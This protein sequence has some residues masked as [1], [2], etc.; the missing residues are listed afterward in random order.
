[1][2]VIIDLQEVRDRKWRSHPQTFA[3]PDRVA[4]A[5]QLAEEA[6]QPGFWERIEAE[7]RERERLYGTGDDEED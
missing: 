7:A 2:A 3:Q 5:R 1:M 6:A 4:H